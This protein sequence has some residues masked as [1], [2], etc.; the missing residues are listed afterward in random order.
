MIGAVFGLFFSSLGFGQ[1]Y[2]SNNALWGA[3]QLT[4]GMSLSGLMYTGT[5]W[6]DIPGMGGSTCVS[7]YTDDTGAMYWENPLDSCTWDSSYEDA[8]YDEEQAEWD[9]Y[10]AEGNAAIEQLIA[11]DNAAA[12]QQA[13]SLLA[14]GRP[15]QINYDDGTTTVILPDGQSATFDNP[16]H[17]SVYVPVY[18]DGYKFDGIG[19]SQSAVDILNDPTRKITSYAQA[20]SQATIDATFAQTAHSLGDANKALFDLWLKR[21]MA[22]GSFGDLQSIE[23]YVGWGDLI[24]PSGGWLVWLPDMGMWAAPG[25]EGDITDFSIGTLYGITGESFSQ[26]EGV[27]QVL[28]GTNPL[29]SYLNGVLMNEL[30]TVTYEGY[31]T[32]SELAGANLESSAF[33]YGNASG[34]VFVF[35]AGTLFSEGGTAAEN[36]AFP[37]ILNITERNLQKGFQKHGAD[38]GI[39]GNWNKAR[40]GEF[41]E[42]VNRHINTPGIQQITGSYRNQPGFTHYLNPN[43]GVNVVVDSAGNYVT[44]YKLGA[45]Q[46]SDVLTTGNLW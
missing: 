14:S 25:G 40:A 29:G 7:M 6:A 5:A 21:D 16:N 39:T 23:T 11:A 41:G 28:S 37:K 45:N 42:A 36:A 12:V 8:A 33:S 10:I 27:N 26:L 19:L 13:N 17:S 9:A 46:L 31:G 38:F 43:T 22:L 35:V 32:L 4:S 18:A 3:Q 30:K 2:N 34:V 15:V 44:G 24:L 1:Y 20:E